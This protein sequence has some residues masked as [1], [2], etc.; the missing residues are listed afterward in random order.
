MDASERKPS[1]MLTRIA[2]EVKQYRVWM[3]MLGIAA[4]IL[5]ILITLIYIAAALYTTTGSFTVRINKVDSATYSMMLSDTENFAQTSVKL[6]ARAAE[7]VTNI[8][9]VDVLEQLKEHDGAHNGDN[10]VASTFYLRNEGNKV[11]S[12]AYEMYISNVT[13]DLDKAVRI[14]VSIDD[15]PPVVYAKWNNAYDVEYVCPFDYKTMELYGVTKN[16]ESDFIVFHGDIMGLRPYSATGDYTK[17]TVV[18]WIEGDDA[19]CVDNKIGGEFRVEMLFSVI[20]AEEFK[21]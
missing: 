16:F 19:D 14:M 15:G 7:E 10:Y 1:S 2:L 5:A 3:R 17:F 9:Y 4:G 8:C 21:K 18:I 20:N 11:L 12:Y 13:R 6:D